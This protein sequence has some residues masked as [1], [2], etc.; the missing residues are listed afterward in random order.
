[1]SWCCVIGSAANVA[2]RPIHCIFYLTPEMESQ[3]LIYSSCQ[4]SL[5]LHHYSLRYSHLKIEFFI[6]YNGPNYYGVMVTAQFTLHCRLFAAIS[7]CSKNGNCL[8]F[9]LLNNIRR[10]A[11]SCNNRLCCAKLYYTL[12]LLW[13]FRQDKVKKLF[14]SNLL[15]YFQQIRN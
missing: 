10:Q 2:S 1:M 8:K 14:F 3:S 5:L 11:S 15:D 12:T 6:R 4:F 9:S 7:I 13:Y